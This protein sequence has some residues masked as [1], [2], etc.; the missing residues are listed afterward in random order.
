MELTQ[1]VRD[2]AASHSLT[3]VEALKAG[4]REKSAGVPQGRRNLREELTFRSVRPC[5][6]RDSR[7]GSARGV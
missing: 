5:L 7:A 6:G 3:D 4:M 2:Y 1:Q